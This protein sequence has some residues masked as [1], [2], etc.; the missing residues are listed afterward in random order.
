[1]PIWSK[2]GD[3]TD[4][5]VHEY[6]VGDDYLMDRVLAE[7]DI[8]GSIGHATMLGAVGLI[9]DAD[10]S[11]LVGGLQTLHK[12]YTEGKWTVEETDEDVHSKVEALLTER[13]GEPAKKLHTGRSRNDQVMTALRLWQKDKLIDIAL[14]NLKSARALCEQAIKY[15]FHPFPGYTHM[16]RGM[17]SSLGQFFGAH[18]TTSLENTVLMHAAFALTDSCP[19][20]SGAG[21]GVGLQLDRELSSKLLG[22]EG[23]IQIAMCDSNSRGKA[24]SV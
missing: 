10:K 4:S 8:L 1:M 17:P 24:E 13:L 18:A 19:L 16:Q 14:S 12:E 7:Y 2:G 20:G 15:E 5:L 9:P 22:F 6:T 3:A 11:A 23:P 21:Y